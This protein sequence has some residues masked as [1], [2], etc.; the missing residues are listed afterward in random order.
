MSSIRP[1]RAWLRLEVEMIIVTILALPSSVAAAPRPQT[2][3]MRRFR[4]GHRLFLFSKATSRWPHSLLGSP[5]G[6]IR[7]ALQPCQPVAN[8]PQW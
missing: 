1:R 4:P 7:P 6:G 8:G 3:I 2:G 5:L